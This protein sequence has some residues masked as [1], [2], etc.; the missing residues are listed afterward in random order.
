M[1]LLLSLFSWLENSPAGGNESNEATVRSRHGPVADGGCSFMQRSRK[2]KVGVPFVR[3][4][5]IECVSV[6]INVIAIRLLT[7]RSFLAPPPPFSSQLLRL[8][9]L[10]QWYCLLVPTSS[11]TAAAYPA[12]NAASTPWREPLE[13]QGRQPFNNYHRRGRQPLV[14][15]ILFPVQHE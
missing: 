3:V 15:H 6:V 7:P 8:L 10:H 14:K 11:R 1:S 5:S 12:R 13:T 4:C 9:I 2:P